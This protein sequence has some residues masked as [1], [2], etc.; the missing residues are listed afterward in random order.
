MFNNARAEALRLAR[1]DEPDDELI[2]VEESDLPTDAQLVVVTADRF[3]ATDRIDD[4]S[5]HA[6]LRDSLDR[7]RRLLA[8]PDP[9]GTT[10]YEASAERLPTFTLIPPSNPEASGIDEPSST[11][12]A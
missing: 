4:D 1:L 11:D 7:L 6:P 5:S 10:L 8:G 12:V 3:V 2:E 9:S